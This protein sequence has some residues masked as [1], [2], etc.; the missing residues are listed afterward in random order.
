MPEEGR[1]LA[2]VFLLFLNGGLGFFFTLSGRVEDGVITTF[3]D[4]LR[5]V[6]QGYYKTPTNQPDPN[7]LRW[8]NI[9]ADLLIPQ[10]GLLGGWTMLTPCLNLLLPPLCRGEKHETRAL[11]MLGVMAGGLPLL[12]THSYLALVLLSLGSCA[13]SVF[14]DGE[15]A[16]RWKRFRPWVLYAAIAAALSLPQL[17]CFTFVPGRGKQSFSAVPV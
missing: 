17:L 2:G 5:T 15:K 14:R 9:V 1:A 6:M 7:N 10:R 3:W 13:Y 16:G 8:S 12:H 4:N 11:V